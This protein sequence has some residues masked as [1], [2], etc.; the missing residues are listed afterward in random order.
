MLMSC[1]AGTTL[2]VFPI[3]AS[4]LGTSAAHIATAPSRPSWRDHDFSVP[5]PLKINPHREKARVRALAWLRHANLITD[6][7]LF[8]DWQ[9]AELASYVYPEADTDDLTLVMELMWW[10]FIPTDDEYDGPWAYRPDLVAERCEELAGITHSPPSAWPKTGPPAVMAWADLWSRIQRGA[11]PSWLTR[12]RYEWAGFL[13]ANVI[14]AVD[15]VGPGISSLEDF[16]WTRRRSSAMYPLFDLGE[17]I[18][19][20]FLPDK[21]YYSRQLSTLRSEANV[22][23]GIMNDVVSADR[24][25]GRNGENTNLLLYLRARHGISREES[26]E[27]ASRVRKEAIGRYIEAEASLSE[28]WCISDSKNMDTLARYTQAVRDHIRGDQE[29]EQTSGRYRK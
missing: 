27:T 28:L 18:N 9:I 5:W 1:Q 12:F 16:F 6:D 13:A 24:E 22:I 14:E 2:G 3:R 19:G 21:I 11:V 29:W 8:T 26:I 20:C 15:R 10:F 4:G 7:H 23:T 25:E 17:R